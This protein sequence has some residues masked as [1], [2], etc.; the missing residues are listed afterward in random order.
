MDPRLKPSAA[1]KRLEDAGVVDRSKEAVKRARREV[2]PPKRKMGQSRSHFVRYRVSAE[3]WREARYMAA[4][5]GFTTLSE[6]MRSLV[7][8][9]VARMYLETKEESQFQT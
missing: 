9:D 5:R 1:T 2:P 6:Y 3:E 8:E 4:A 7:R